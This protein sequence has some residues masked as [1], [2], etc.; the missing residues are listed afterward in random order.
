[1][2]AVLLLAGCGHR[3]LS[4]APSD[5][6]RVIIQSVGDVGVRLTRTDSNREAAPYILKVNGAVIGND[7]TGLATHVV[8]K[9]GK[10]QLSIRCLLP[11]SAIDQAPHNAPAPF[12]RSPNGE[13]KISGVSR[14]A[15]SLIELTDELAAGSS[16]DLRCA[17]I[18]ANRARAWLTVKKENQ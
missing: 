5:G 14:Q 17:A 11:G 13:G 10:V 16:Y 1:M 6:T 18:G 3:T 8:T 7:L 12:S 15:F 2:L 9:P 4:D